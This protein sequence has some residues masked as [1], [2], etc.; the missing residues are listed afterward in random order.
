MVVGGG[1]GLVHMFLKFNSIAKIFLKIEKL[2]LLLFGIL[3]FAFYLWY[4]KFLLLILNVKKWNKISLPPN[5]PS[6]GIR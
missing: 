1:G 2:L 5:S 4:I 3:Q 6:G